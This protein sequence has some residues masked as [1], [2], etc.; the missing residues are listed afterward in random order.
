MEYLKAIKHSKHQYNPDP[1]LMSSSAIFCPTHLNSQW[2][3]RGVKK[4]VDTFQKLESV[5]FCHFCWEIIA[6]YS[7]ITIFVNLDSVD[8]PQLIILLSDFSLFF[9][10]SLSWYRFQCS[11]TCGTTQ[12]EVASYK[13][14][15]YHEDWVCSWFWRYSLGYIFVLCKARHN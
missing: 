8:R 15:R 11:C 3:Y 1:K 13:L 2:Y 12:G 9:C 10:P 7:I 6:N 14:I 4:Q 5:N